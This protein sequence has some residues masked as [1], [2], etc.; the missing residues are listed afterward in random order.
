M[1]GRGH[2]RGGV[3]DLDRPGYREKNLPLIEALVEATDATLSSSRP[4]VGNGWL[5]KNRQVCQ[6]GKVVMPDV[7]IAVGISGA[8]KHVAGMKGADTIVA[9]NTDPSAPV[10][11][12]TDYGI[13][14]DLFEVVPHLIKELGGE[15]PE[16]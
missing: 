4:I 12:L 5:P 13:K 14:G 7:Y 8:V 1:G 10:Y 11:D 3:I 15:V 6:S 2:Q 16:V 9:I